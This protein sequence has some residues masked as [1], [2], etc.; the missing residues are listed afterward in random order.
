M[1]FFLTTISQKEQQKMISELNEKLDEYKRKESYGLYRSSSE[2]MASLKDSKESMS[3]VSLVE[4]PSQQLAP[5]G[6]KV[7]MTPKSSKVQIVVASDSSKSDFTSEET[8]KP[9]P[10]KT[11]EESSKEIAQ[12]KESLE[13]VQEELK[14]EKEK[15][16]AFEQEFATLQ[17]EKVKVEQE[18]SELEIQLED[19]KRENERAV[20]ELN[21]K[22]EDME[23]ENKRYVD[24]LLCLSPRVKVSLKREQAKI[25]SL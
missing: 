10:S 22:L 14:I 19:V 9:E 7:I 1:H 17:T 15:S 11:S 5:T 13:R 18:R 25:S 6:E 8:A 3:V 23:R 16:L 12:L 21:Q 2:S 20:E 4:K 24:K